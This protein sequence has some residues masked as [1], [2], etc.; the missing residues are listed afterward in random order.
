MLITV[1]LSR[2]K[3]AVPT[4]EG[5]TVGADV[6]KRGTMLRNGRGPGT[7]IPKGIL[8][9][10]AETSAR[11]DR[12]VMLPGTVVNPETVNLEM[13]NP[14]LGFLSWTPES[15]CLHPFQR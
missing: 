3:P 9:N 15:I 8:W 11:V 13:S 14:D 12:I 6:V 10:P 1:G 4:L 5:A 7:L 2:L